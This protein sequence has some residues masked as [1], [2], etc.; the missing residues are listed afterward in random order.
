MPC[1]AF[2]L[3]TQVASRAFTFTTGTEANP[4][5]LRRHLSPSLSYYT[6]CAPRAC[7]SASS[8]P[9]NSGQR[10]SSPN[11]TYHRILSAAISKR[12]TEEI[13]T[14][15][16]ALLNAP[17][18]SSI[19]VSTFR[20]ILSLCVTRKDLRVL[21]SSL[22]LGL[23]C[24]HITRQLRLPF[25]MPPLRILATAGWWKPVYSSLDSMQK[26]TSFVPQ[27]APD[28]RM[29]VSLANIAVNNGA[30]SHSLRLFDWM[31]ANALPF[32]PIAFSVLLKS[33]GRAG[34]IVAVKEVIKRI[35][36]ENVSIDTILLNSA[37]DALVRC[38]DVR[39]ARNMLLN[40]SYAQLVDSTTYN[41]VIK[42]CVADRQI[43][44]AFQIATRMQLAGLK[45]TPVTINTLLA[46]CVAANDIDTAWQ[47]FE[48]Y[49]GES[50]DKLLPL[51]SYQRP[52][53]PSPALKKVLASPSQLD[54]INPKL[55]VEETELDAEGTEGGQ[56]RL[57][58]S[59]AS[60]AS[61]RTR[62]V[63]TKVTL[64][65]ESEK[66]L[67]IA[68]TTLLCGLTKSGR[69]SEALTVLDSME[70]RGAPPN[71]ITYASLIN[72]CFKVGEMD[73]A[74]RIFRSISRTEK[75]R[76]LPLCDINICNVVVNGL[77]RLDDVKFIDQAAILAKQMLRSRT[78][79]SKARV[80]AKKPPVGI[81]LNPENL[82][83][84]IDV[85]VLMLP[86]ADTFN[87]LLEGYVRF[88]DFE[89]AEYF[90]DMMHHQRLRPNIVSYTTLMK[91]YADAGQ[92]ADAKRT[93]H[94]IAR[95][96][97]NPDRVALNAFV[98]VCARSNDAMAARKVIGFMEKRGGGISPTSQSYTPMLN[99]Y[100]RTQNDP[101]LWALYKRM[102]S[103][104]VP[105]NDYVMEFL[106]EFIITMGLKNNIQ[107]AELDQLATNSAQLLR[108]GVQDAV[109]VKVLRRSKR[110]L[111]SLFPS[112]LRAKYFGGLDSFEFQSVS[113]T[114]FQRHGW[115]NI[116]S[117]WR[118]L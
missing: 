12:R 30:Y 39:A 42:G 43:Q 33:H 35:R 91:G 69:L 88:N 110:K 24:A 21:S 59:L 98:A 76:K 31:T 57:S 22:R 15:L 90:L 116:D 14:P 17:E 51:P 81:D 64:D 77:C 65:P 114:I 89:S 61:K 63:Q 71:S 36:H 104:G 68:M 106:T 16:S 94:E 74:I 72:S 60:N 62:Q 40:Q 29:V 66:Q 56:R 113:E 13:P 20:S 27:L 8:Q 23:S 73:E 2:L 26:A 105:V 86:T 85:S 41:T 97:I 52:R 19:T 7:Q 80:S 10:I 53:S 108:D 32:G 111:M 102:R 9:F 118:I 1:S 115:N 100:A 101:R 4:L 117:G 58:T 83:E 48:C 3:P 79:G 38:D 46:G 103:Q 93:F 25:L 67:R 54:V 92:H 99:Y 96:K 70:N 50:A 112:S 84:N 55:Q 28:A 37:I 87:A 45:L 34:N 109:T 78:I 82:F 18:S 107:T 11:E 75:G 49:S 44:S 5:S 95:H 47:L 6:S